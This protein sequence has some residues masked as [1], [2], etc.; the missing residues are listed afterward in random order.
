[1]NATDLDTATSASRQHYIDTGQY[2]TIQE[3]ASDA[4][5]EDGDTFELP[6]GSSLRLRFAPDEDAIGNLR[7][8]GDVWGDTSVY[9]YDYRSEAHT[10]RP[11]G[12]TGN[13]EKIQMDR[14]YW[15]W[16]EPPSDVP[17][18]SPH[19]KELRQEVRDL[20]EYG[21]QGI[22]VE[23]LRGMDAYGRSIVVNVASLW[24][25]EPFVDG[26]YRA[27]IVADLVHEVL[28]DA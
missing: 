4:L 15:K 9:A 24:G 20:L 11:D 14:G 18:S 3:T 19:F 21:F 22:I 27:E 8:H 7:D 28:A 2:L 26:A 6:D 13:A 1:M 10:P 25:I 16:W 23:H 5:T 17:R 12:F